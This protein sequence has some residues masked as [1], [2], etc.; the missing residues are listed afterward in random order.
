MSTY[1][2]RFECIDCEGDCCRHGYRVLITKK[3]MEE[4]LQLDAVKRVLEK[5]QCSFLNDH[6]KKEY[7]FLPILDKEGERQ[8]AFLDDDFLCLIHKEHGF[9]AK[10]DV[11][12]AYPFNVVSYSNE[13]IRVCYSFQ[14]K[15]IREN[16]GKPII[17]SEI[18][19]KDYILCKELP[20]TLP[21]IKSSDKPLKKEHYCAPWKSI[22][23]DI[24]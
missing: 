22:A 19:G 4:L 21:T 6:I 18:I 16:Y 5:E 10:P 20:E 2:Q 12:K 23:N 13:E 14:C 15:S 17:D 11:C 8:C 1:S 7:Y 9:D 3:S 24:R